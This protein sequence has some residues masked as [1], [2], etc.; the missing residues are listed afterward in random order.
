MILFFPIHF[1]SLSSELRRNHAEDLLD[2]Y[3]TKFTAHSASLGLRIEE[4]LNYDRTQLGKD[5]IQSLL[6]A[7]LLCIGSVDVA[8]GNPDTEQRLLDVLQDLYDQGV[9]SVDAQ[10]STE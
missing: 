2:H 5:F 3:W 9:L 6:L 1:S 8:L 10:P 7:L 4:E